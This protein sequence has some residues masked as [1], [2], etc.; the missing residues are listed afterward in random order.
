MTEW[1]TYTIADF[2]MYSSRTWHRLIEQHNA[3]TWPF[4]LLALFLGLVIWIVIRRAPGMHG[5]A[6]S[7]ILVLAW[8]S[9]GFL[10]HWLRYTTISTGARWFALAFGVEALL[11]L[12][13]GVVREGLSFGIRRSVAGWCGVVLLLFGA[14]GYPLIAILQGRGL[15]QAEVFG[16]MPDPTA[17][18]TLGALLLATG[19]WR[20]VLF[21]IPL[22]WCLVSGALLWA[23]NREAVDTGNGHLV[24]PALSLA[25]A[26]APRRLAASHYR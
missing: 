10:F 17:I 15:A 19:R 3:A 24:V 20:R 22:L 6:I 21:V 25:G 26:Q 23:M 7:T 16:I 5:R 18:A 11:L 14:L 4:Q 12:W 13:I 2:L 9:S 8:L 1:W